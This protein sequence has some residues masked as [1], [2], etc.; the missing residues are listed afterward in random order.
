MVILDVVVD[1]VPVSV[2]EVAAILSAVLVKV[3]TVSSQVGA[4]RTVI[5]MLLSIV[6]AVLAVIYPLIKTGSRTMFCISKTSVITRPAG[7]WS[8]SMSRSIGFAI[9]KD[10]TNSGQ[11]FVRIM[12]DI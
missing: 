4:F 1:G 7:H 6:R 10:K 2:V 8:A 11:R 5:V 9:A 3:T 12:L